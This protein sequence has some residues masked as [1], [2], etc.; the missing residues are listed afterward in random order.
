MD[1]KIKKV[2]GILIEINNIIGQFTVIVTQKKDRQ[3]RVS[4]KFRSEYIE[5]P[6]VTLNQ[7][8]VTLR[9]GSVSALVELNLRNNGKFYFEIFPDDPQQFTPEWFDALS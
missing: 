3:G 7:R 9:L 1:T 5:S 8:Q 2:L 4:N 6:D